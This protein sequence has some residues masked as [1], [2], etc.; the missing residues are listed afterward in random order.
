MGSESHLRR[1]GPQKAS[2]EPLGALLE[3]SGAE[4]KK[5]GTALGRLGPKKGA[6]IGGPNRTL[7]RSKMPL[8]AQE[9]LRGRRGAI[10]DQF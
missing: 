5:L 7:N 9:A 10:L 6:N 2:G 1:G 4:K 3:A 8:G